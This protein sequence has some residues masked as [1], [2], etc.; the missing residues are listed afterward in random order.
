[1]EANISSSEL[2]PLEEYSFP[3]SSTENMFWNFSGIIACGDDL[4][5]LS[6][7]VVR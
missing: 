3:L 5:K 6:D 1:M 2:F 7:H 4:G